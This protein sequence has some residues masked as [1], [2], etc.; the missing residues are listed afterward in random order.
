[1]IGLAWTLLKNDERYAN[2]WTQV[3]FQIYRFRCF[4]RPNVPEMLG[5]E[6]NVYL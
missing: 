3:Q 6:S 2:C 4:T 5:L 1:M